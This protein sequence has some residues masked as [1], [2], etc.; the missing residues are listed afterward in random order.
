MTYSTPA[1]QGYCAAAA[2][3]PFHG[4]YHDE[5]YGFPVTDDDELFE[6]LVLEMNQAGLSWLTILKKK[7][8][9]QQAYDGFDLTK[10]AGYDETDRARLLADS[11]IIRN[12]LKVDAAIHNAGQILKIQDS[13]GSFAG[14]LASHHPKPKVDWVKLFKANF[15]FTGGEITGEFLMSVGYLPDAH[16]PNCPVHARILDLD[17]PWAQVESGRP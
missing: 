16:D 2:G 15:R 7:D 12:G 4:P 11:G 6:R 1:L 5:E 3:H 9:F 17:P 14:W 13:H 8:T 10:V